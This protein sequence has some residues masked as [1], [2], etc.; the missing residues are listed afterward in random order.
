MRG[1]IPESLFRPSRSQHTGWALFRTLLYSAVLWILLIGFA[2]WVLAKWE[3]QVWVEPFTFPGQTVVAWLLFLA[4]A[5]L[6]VLSGW[7][8]TVVGKGTPLPLDCAKELVVC[9][10]YRYVRNP[11]AIGGLGAAFS[12]GIWLGSYFVLLYAILGG[13]VWN[14]MVRPSEEADLKR[15]FGNSYEVYR[16]RVRCWWPRWRQ[17]TALPAIE[18]SER[19]MRSTKDP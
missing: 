3:R 13:I 16:T 5:C 19:A 17:E 14:A 12:V 1:W 7:T 2:P 15:R 11:M 18:N 8:M 10:P 9:G 6:N 4:M